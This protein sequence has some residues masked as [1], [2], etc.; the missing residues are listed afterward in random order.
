MVSAFGHLAVKSWC[1]LIAATG[2]T[3]LGLAI[4]TFSTTIAIWV[5]TMGKEWLKRPGAPFIAGL[6]AMNGKQLAH[7][8]SSHLLTAP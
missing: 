3:T 2:T 4:W 1:A 8:H 5:A 7:N 6:I